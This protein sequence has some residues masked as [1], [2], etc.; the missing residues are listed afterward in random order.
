MVVLLANYVSMGFLLP[1]L[2]PMAVHNGIA[3][4]R[5]AAGYYSGLVASMFFCGRALSSCLWGSFADRFGGKT[6]LLISL[7]ASA[8][9]M[10]GFGCSTTLLEMCAW[11]FLAGAMN[12]TV[13]VCKAMALRMPSDQIR[14]ALTQCTWGLGLLL[15][16]AMGG[17]LAQPC[18]GDS[19]LSGL[20]DWPAEGAL[21]RHPYLLPGLAGALLHAAALPF[22][23]ALPSAAERP[24]PLRWPLPFG[25]GSECRPACGDPARASRADLTRTP[26]FSRGGPSCAYKLASTEDPD[27]FDLASTVDDL[28]STVISDTDD[29]ADESGWDETP[30]LEDGSPRAASRLRAP[31]PH[32]E[33]GELLALEDGRLAPETS[34]KEASPCALVEG[35]G[36]RDDQKGKDAVATSTRV[37]DDVSRGRARGKEGD[38]LDAPGARGA[39]RSPSA[40]ALRKR[41]RFLLVLAVQA[42]VVTAMVMAQELS[43]MWCILPVSRGGLQWSPK[44]IGQAWAAFGVAVLGLQLNLVPLVLKRLG[45]L[46]TLRAALLV[47]VFLN[48]A[49]PWIGLLSPDLPGLPTIQFVLFVGVVALQQLTNQLAFSSVATLL[50]LASPADRSARAAGLGLS[51]Q[52]ACMAVGPLVAGSVLAASAELA[53]PADARTRAHARPTRSESP[54]DESRVQEI[55][56]FLSGGKFTPSK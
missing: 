5:V 33:V 54:R 18:A 26:S 41:R 46:R 17:L 14:S 22:W 51:I 3:E 38:L 34:P 50:S 29:D 19:L 2:G 43:A 35:R 47:L 21:C 12:G 44:T 32:D 31:A 25:L 16:P 55:G 56:D 9:S 1:F 40:K 23:L 6:V 10:V 52:S 27:P 45:S 8:V 13:P 20:A 7:V 39:T 30:A 28:A 24:C 4:D 11:R 53:E 36:G 49:P 37:A 42:L 48:A 15:G